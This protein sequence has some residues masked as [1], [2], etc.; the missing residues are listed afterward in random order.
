[1]ISI[2]NNFLLLLLNDFISVTLKT[3][4]CTIKLKKRKLFV[5]STFVTEFNEYLI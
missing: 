2:L 4:P 3:R 1:M 5:S